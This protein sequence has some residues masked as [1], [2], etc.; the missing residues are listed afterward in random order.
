MIK[1]VLFFKYTYKK[2]VSI[3]IFIFKF[4]VTSILLLSGCAKTSDDLNY[5]FCVSHLEKDRKNARDHEAFSY[6]S[7]TFIEWRSPAVYRLS[8]L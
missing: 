5:N 1:S 2:L 8:D 4:Y 3:L 7:K 6:Q